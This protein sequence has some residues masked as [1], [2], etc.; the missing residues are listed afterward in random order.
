MT[1]SNSEST[2]ATCSTG[3]INYSETRTAC[4]A[5]WGEWV[6]EEYSERFY[7]PARGEIQADGENIRDLNIKEYRQRL[8][9]VSQ[10]P[11]LYQGTIRD[12]IVLGTDK[13]DIEEEKIIS[14]CKQ[15][16]IY[17]FIMSLP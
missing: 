12:N 15:A 7:D 13:A 1:V 5:S 3:L 9:L 16:N 17:D 6:R 8:A 4:C 2:R 10:E 11:T 14:V